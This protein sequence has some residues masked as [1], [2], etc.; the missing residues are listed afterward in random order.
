M[1]SFCLVAWMGR[2]TTIVIKNNGNSFS[3]KT[4]TANVGDTISFDITSDHNVVEV[5]KSTYDANGETGNGG[6][7]IPF[8]GGKLRLSNAGTF[9]F[10]CQPHAS[11]GMKGILTVNQAV[12]VQKRIVITNAGP[13]TAPVFSPSHVTAAI[14]DTIDFQVNPGFHDVVEVSR[15][16]WLANDSVPL[17]GGFKL[18]FGGGKYIVSKSGSIFFTCQP[19]ARV[20]MKG[21]INLSADPAPTS[22]VA[23]LSG[24]QEEFPV[25]GMASGLFK[26]TLVGDTLKV[27]GSFKNLTGD[28]NGGIHL[29]EGL[30]G[31]SGPV[32]LTL[33]AIADSTK[34]SG[35]V[36]DTF[37][38]LNA[39]QKVLLLARGY[40]GNVHTTTSPG[41]EIRGQLV[42]ESE[43]YYQA[44]LTGLQEAPPV[45]TSAHGSIVAELTGNSLVVTGSAK[46]ISSGINTAIRQG[47]HL[48]LGFPGQAGGIQLELKPIVDTSGT[49]AQYAAI[50][51]TFTLT[52]DQI[53]ALKAGQLYANMHSIQYPG[54]EIRGQVTRIG[55]ARFRVHYSGAY[56]PVPVNTLASGGLSLL[57]EDSTLSVLGSFNGLESNWITG[58]AHLHKGMAGQ[59]GGVQITFKGNP[60][61]DLRSGTFSG[62]SN[63]FKLTSTNL[64]DLF[65]RRL[66]AN[67]H[68]VNYPGGELR[69]QVI[70][71]CQYVLFSTM[72]GLQEN[73]PVNTTGKGNILVEVNGTKLTASGYA[74]KLS[75]RVTAS[76][77]HKAF[78]GINA[79]VLTNLTFTFPTADSLSIIYPATSN[80]YTVSAGYLDSLRRRQLYSNVHTTKNPGGEIRGQLAGEAAAYFHTVLSGAEE[81]PAV[82][83]KGVGGLMIEYQGGG[84][85]NMVVSG[86]FQN[87]T[88]KF[89]PAAAGGA[90][91]HA[92]VAGS[93][94]GIR[95]ALTTTLGADS[96]SGAFLPSNNTISLTAAGVDSLRKRLFYGNIH[97]TTSP[98]GEIRGYIT[99]LVNNTFLANLSGLNELPPTES[100]GSGAIKAELL[101]NVLT[102]T[103]SFAGLTGD[104]NKN[105]AGGSHLHNGVNGSNG[106]IILNL[107]ASVNADNKSGFFAADSNSFVL[108][109]DQLNLLNSGSLYANVHTTT[110]AGGEIRG[111]LLQEINNFP[112]ASTITSPKVTDTVK[113]D[114]RLKDST[115]TI[116]WAASTDPDGNPLTYKIQS[117]VFPNFAIFTTNV[118]GGAT[119]FKTTFGSIDS[120][121]ATLGVPVGGSVNLFNRVITS[122]GS[123]NTTGTPSS[124]TLIRAL[125]TNVADAFAKSFSMM[126]Y[127]VPAIQNAVLEINANKSTNLDL[128]IIDVS[129]RLEH[130]EKLSVNAGMNHY[131]LDVSRYNTGTHFIQLYQNGTHV[132][133][134][135]IIKE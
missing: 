22:F 128:R 42:P 32:R 102:V 86:A 25:L 26:A 12:P 73:K 95:Y 117:S 51:N 83:T 48:H 4:V 91:I 11:F 134:F 60:A 54:G 130:K 17:E 122:D 66:Y 126:V 53:T 72:T 34:K 46:D 119:S 96:L 69:G 15:A 21:T 6:F 78:T 79:G 40:Y 124:V 94:G 41:G 104:F 47:G 131:T 62:D 44:N 115:V 5:S 88:G 109:A 106:G 68:S 121:M 74:E 125:T 85:R 55:N 107:K 101:N 29:H 57:L 28:F 103:G 8:G 14:G 30:P 35:V 112:N 7:N 90:H 39:A 67:V 64:D 81:N 111:Q 24:I 13:F 127:P 23:K 80:V 118:A 82:N 65:S 63:S 9:Y 93:N 19:H 71:E 45:M 132:A 97:T 27:S 133:Y 31:T 43:A 114:G 50:D 135:K 20:G 1:L 61:S 36:V 70:P 56:E 123:L 2:S 99:N 10:V 129:G 3:P 120:V 87:L 89:N 59:N 38:V 84:N 77:F 18:P 113:I 52:A 37:F 98:G 16:T 76:H 33:R 108:T 75:T 116:S 92:G 100:T 110:S 105:I 49:A 58:L